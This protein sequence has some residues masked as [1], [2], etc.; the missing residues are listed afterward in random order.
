ME[1]EKKVTTTMH[2]AAINPRYET[3]IVSAKE[4]EVRGIDF[5]TWGTDNRYPQYIWGL[6][7]DVTLIRTIVNGIADYVCGEEIKFN[8]VPWQMRI[9]DKGETI[10][11]LVRSLG[12]DLAMY[13]GFAF[14]VI[15]NKM[16]GIAQIC[17]LDFKNLRSDRNNEFFFY[18]DD[19]DKTYGRV[20]YHKYPKFRTDGKEVSSIYYYKNSRNTTYP[21]P[22]IEGDAAVA[23][24]TEKGISEFH[25]NSIK[26][27]FSAN[28]II[29]F[30]NGQ[31]TSEEQEE[32]ER[33]LNEKFGGYQNAG[34]MMAA[35]NDTKD[36]SVTV[37]K[38]SAEDFGE[39]YSALSKSTKQEIYSAFRA[40][41]QLFGLPT[42]GTGFNDMDYAEA[43]KIFNKTVILPMQKTIKR[44]LEYVLGIPEVIEIV[45]FA[46]DWDTEGAENK[47]LVK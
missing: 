7:N 20:K 24:E 39:R 30:N 3:N 28:V 6:Q 8:Y 47:E 12:W 4:T 5:I 21:I 46:I 42:E 10:E 27:G 22:P 17:Y 44:S 40:H 13:G 25:L 18:A 34:R 9:N 32:V 14:N 11:D 36:N 29:N 31:P 37:E 1:D 23:A 45:P 15:R 26:N 33:N 16:G 41:P 19:W 35:F 2:F 38:I 43:F